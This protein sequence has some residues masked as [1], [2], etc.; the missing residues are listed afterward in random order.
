MR[1][2][3]YIHAADLHLDT[4]FQGLRKTAP[5]VHAQL[6]NASLVA[7]DAL[8]ELA[9]ERGA[10]F[11]LLAGDLYDGAERGV[12]A[13]LR[14]RSG[15]RK[16]SAAG[17][18]VFIVHGNHDPLEQGWS[19]IGEWPEGVTVFP[20]GQVT[21]A[22]V[23]RGGETIATVHGRSYAKRETRE[24]LSIDFRRT[25]ES[26]LH[27]GL[28]HCNVGG[29]PGH[30]NYSPCSVEDLAA[31]DM[32]Y[33]ALGHVHKHAVIKD[34]DPWVVYPGNLQGRSPQ[35]GERGAK[36]AVVVD[37]DGA[38]VTN[39]EHVALDR[40]RFVEHELDVSGCSDVGELEEQLVACADKQH[41][42]AGGRGVLLRARLVEASAALAADLERGDNTAEL[43]TALRDRYQGVEPFLWWD[44]LRIE[45]ATQPIE[46]RSD[47]FSASLD[48]LYESLANDPN[49]IDDLV[50]ASF[51]K[52]P[53]RKKGVTIQPMSEVEG[54]ELLGEAREIARSL[55]GAKSGA[56]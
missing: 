50:A 52:L 48:E 16:L 28:L 24:N 33:W 6:L 34:G 42:L 8:V 49:A 44:S 40:V 47:D 38:R 3:C 17:I 39:V 56:E 22:Q 13:Q 25:S 37:V 10:Q 21:S 30:E 23:A 43:L 1:Q 12:R 14:F 32:D 20:S 11:M 4:P 53:G 7:W 55:L 35:P 26:G 27:I 19:A 45:A 31:A 51:E 9:L 2:F 46:R 5:D 36:G 18:E 54:G 15:V 29:A 41:E